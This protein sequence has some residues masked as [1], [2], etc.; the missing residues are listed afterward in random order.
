[1]NKEI[2]ITDA[3]EKEWQ[4]DGSF[5]DMLDGYNG[6]QLQCPY[7]FH[8][9]NPEWSKGIF[10]RKNIAD[11][12]EQQIQNGIDKKAGELFIGSLSDPYM[13]LEEE[14]Q[15]TRKML[16]VLCDKDYD[17]RITTKSDNRLILR[18]AELLKQFKRPVRILMGLSNIKQ[19][20]KGRNNVNIAVANEL[21]KQGIDVW[22]FITPILP[23]VMNVDEMIASVDDN[24]PIYLDKLRISSKGNQDK[25]I[26]DWI[27][28]EYPQYRDVYY[29]LLFERDESYYAEII[30]KYK[31]DARITFMFEL[32]GK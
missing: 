7:C 32:W 3:F 21:K 17:V 22:I 5:V 9:D 11:V 28:R 13:P 24:I 30:D 6:C 19:A 31:D 10:I 2:M 12:L 29:K 26:Q 15:L 25:M 4:P 23:Y 27:C 14:Y 18:D 1:M 8:K 20:G 16:R